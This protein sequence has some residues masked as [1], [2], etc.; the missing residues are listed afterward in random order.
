MTN[1]LEIKHLSKSYNGIP[2]LRDINLSIPAGEIHG[3]IG[4]NGSGKTTLM[5]ILFGN[6]VIEATGGYEG[7]IYFNGQKLSSRIAARP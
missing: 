2:A 6:P 4:A 3:L 1:L 5:N 7:E